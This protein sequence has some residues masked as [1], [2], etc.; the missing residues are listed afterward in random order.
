MTWRTGCTWHFLE[1]NQGG[2]STIARAGKHSRDCRVETR[3]N[4]KACGL[5]MQELGE[6]N[7]L[8]KKTFH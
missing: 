7:Q 3:L 2:R 5:T 8:P 6:Y 1:P 4:P